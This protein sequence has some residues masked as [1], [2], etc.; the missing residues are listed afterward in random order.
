[1]SESKR[2]FRPLLILVKN[3]VVVAAVSYLLTIT[4]ANYLGPADFGLYAHVLIVSSVVSI[5]VNFGT[6]QTAAVSFS[7]RNDIRIVFEEVFYTRAMVLIPTLGMVAFIYYQEVQILFFVFCLTLTNFNLGFL[8]EVMRNNERYSYI[9]LLERVFYVLLAF[10]LIY[11]NRLNLYALFTISFFFAAVSIFWQFND[12]KKYI[13]CLR[14]DLVNGSVKVLYD[15][16]PLVVI[17]LSTYA[18]GGF[19]RLVLERQL[20]SESLGIYSAGWQLIA[21]GTIFQTQISRI[22][23]LD[24]TESVQSNNWLK[25]RGSLLS[26]VLISSIPMLLLCLFFYGNSRLVVSILYTESYAQLATI[27]PILGLYFLVINLSGIVDMLWVALRRNNT[28]LLINL[29][30]G[31]AFLIVLIYFSK[32]MSMVHFAVSAV[33]AHLFTALLLATVWVHY[34]RQ[35]I[36]K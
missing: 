4:L 29:I 7:R 27:L 20:G 3:S 12:N 6:E 1:M 16:V 19:S 36:E 9:H 8:Y 18:Y 10:V 35:R 24:I 5:F 30:S 34:F 15:N 2:Y 33:S 21:I 14:P 17:A 25:L 22:W 26:Y 13:S 31:C 32:S 23:R 28:F 11:T